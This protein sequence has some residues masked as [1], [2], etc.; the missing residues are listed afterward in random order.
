[1]PAVSGI[2]KLTVTSLPVDRPA[3]VGWKR[4]DPVVVTAVA[5]LDG[6]STISA[7]RLMSGLHCVLTHRGLVWQARSAQSIRPLPSSSTPLLQ[8]SGVAAG[9]VEILTVVGPCVPVN[10][11]TITQ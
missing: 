8:I 7:P 11:C 6:P 5:F 1:M 2:E 4:F 10:D 3:Q 9:P